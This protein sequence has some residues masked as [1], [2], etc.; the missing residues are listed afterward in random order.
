MRISI[1]LLMGSI[2]A[3]SISIHLLRPMAGAQPAAAEPPL[4]AVVELAEAVRAEF[5]PVHWAPGSVLSRY[6]ARIAS[7]Q[8][9]KLMQ[10]VEVGDTVRSGQLLARL[11]DSVLRLRASE[12]HARLARINTQRD[13]SR[14]QLDRFEQLGQRGVVSQSQIDQLRG[15]LSMLA[16]EAEAAR[17]ALEQIN[18]RVGQHEIRAPFDGVVAERHAQAGELVAAGTAL[19]RLVDIHAIELRVHAPVAMAERLR[20]GI[21]VRLA[22]DGAPAF[23]RIAAVVPVGDEASRQLELRIALDDSDLPVG[24]ALEAGLPAAEPRSVVAVPHDAL[25][26]RRD[27]S[28]VMRVDDN[29][30]A[31]RIE[32]KTGQ[33]VDSFVEVIGDIE[34]GDR[35]IIRGG[36]RLQPGQ[37]VSLRDDDVLVVAMSPETPAARTRLP[38][39]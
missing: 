2:L 12:E 31:Q 7:E 28:F 6:D 32:V 15:E 24:A 9:G 4:P 13:L 26:L 16:H 27:G 38:Q 14:R 5:A 3:L 19:L 29:D 30:Q 17:L 10:I 1:K 39:P 18:L 36:E 23:G 37:R 8:T 35:L 11:D 22:G 20:T 34:P 21:Q 25:L 33:Q